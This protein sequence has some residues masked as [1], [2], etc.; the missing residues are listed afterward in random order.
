MRKQYK[1][2]TF[3]DAALICIEN[4]GKGV[5]NE[6]GEKGIGNCHKLFQV[7]CSR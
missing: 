3:F 7:L 2:G 6:K 5:N 4:T 1:S